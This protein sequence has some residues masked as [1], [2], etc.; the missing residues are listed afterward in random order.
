[1]KILQITSC[2]YEGG[3]TETGLVMRNEI[4]HSKGHTVVT[5]SSD[6]RP[7][8][9]HFSNYEFRAP[10]DKFAGKLKKT[11]F[12]LDAYRT[13]RR[14]CASFRPDIV[15][16]HTL[17]IASASVLYALRD[18]NVVLCVHGAE[19]Y[20]GW[21]LPFIIPEEFY[22]TH[23]YD[24]SDLTPCG[25]AQY[26]YLRWLIRPIFM[27][28]IK[29]LEN[30]IAFSRYTQQMLAAEGVRS[31]YI[32]NGVELFTPKPAA[33]LSMRVGYAGRLDKNKGLEH[34]FEAFALTLHDLPD[35][36]LVLAGD[37]DLREKLEETAKRLGIT[38][39]V[40]FCGRLTRPQM[41]EFYRGID[42]LLMA[43]HQET[44]GKVGV[45]AMSAGTPVVAPRVGGIVEWLQHN[46]NGYFVAGDDPASYARTVVEAYRD[47][48]AL[49][50]MS[51]NATA[52][53]QRFDM[54]SYVDT[55]IEYFEQ[56][57][58]AGHQKARPG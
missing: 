46:H 9:S 29:R 34:I 58:A 16:V 6:S 39:N 30:V 56:I 44:F 11:V 24:I 25:K 10:S 38:G 54:N 35:L 52:T 41:G 53:A 36:E 3:G 17:H 14:L 2:G 7:D 48:H 20:T 5:L 15:T 43:S 8:L 37:G 51:N 27:A 33:G 28:R 50:E 23:P 19:Y 22:R 12:N 4:L 47:P 42:L 18:E 1:M 45:E 55:Q 49:R 13:T 40:A 21:L 31:R 26:A 57:V 32:P